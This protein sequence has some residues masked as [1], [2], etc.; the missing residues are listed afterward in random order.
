MIWFHLFS[1]SLC[2]RVNEMVKRTFIFL[3]ALGLAAFGIPPSA[4]QAHVTPDHSEPRVGSTVKTPPQIVRIWFDGY[5]EPAFS[6]IKV[7][8]KDEKRVDKQNGQ[9]S[10]SDPTL[11]EVG[12]PRLLPGRYR[13]IWN[14]VAVDSHRTE[15]DFWFTVQESP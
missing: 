10:G 13:V 3:L 9:V 14:V 7:Y 1:E 12:L 5:L 8:S 15:G 4:V 11:L 6:T 2:L